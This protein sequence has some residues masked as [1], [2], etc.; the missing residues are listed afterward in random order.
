M[1]KISQIIFGITITLIYI[2]ASILATINNGWY[3]AALIILATYFFILVLYQIKLSNNEIK[4]E[5]LLEMLNAGYTNIVNF[6]RNELNSAEVEIGRK[7]MEGDIPSLISFLNLRS[8]NFWQFDELGLNI[9]FHLYRHCIE[10]AEGS[11]KF[12]KFNDDFDAWDSLPSNG[13]ETVH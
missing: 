10:A 11:E 3:F 13:D 4:Q 12:F 5:I 2:Y 9:N 7:A 1:K 6:K 8:L